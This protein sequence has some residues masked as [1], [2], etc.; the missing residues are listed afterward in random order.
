[1]VWNSEWVMKNLV[2]VA[3]GYNWMAKPTS[4]K[5]EAMKVLEAGSSH[6]PGHDSFAGQR[7]HFLF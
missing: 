7:G 6:L 3:L 1:M 5:G 2:S 4:A